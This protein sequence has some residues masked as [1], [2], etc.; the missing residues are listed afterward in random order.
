ML[1][2]IAAPLAFSRCPFS[3]C[4]SLLLGLA[5]SCLAMS[6]LAF[7]APHPLQFFDRC[8]TNTWNLGSSEWGKFAASVRHPKA[9]TFS[10]SGWASPPDPWPG[11]LPLETAGAPPPD[12]RYRLALR[13]RHVYPPHI[14][15]PGDVPAL[16]SLSSS[17]VLFFTHFTLLMP[18]I[19][20]PL[21]AY[22]VRN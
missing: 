13:A 21:V 12:P 2:K 20:E 15:W 17:V 8:I 11:A 16:S 9:K 3:R 5:L 14:F 10:A 18:V 7:S 6:C 19:S 22:T 1:L 4:Q